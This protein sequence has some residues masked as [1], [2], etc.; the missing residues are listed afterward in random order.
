MGQQIKKNLSSFYV[1]IHP[2][3]L[4]E[5]IILTVLLDTKGV[6]HHLSIEK[7]PQKRSEQENVLIENLLGGNKGYRWLTS[8]L[9]LLHSIRYRTDYKV[10]PNLLMIQNRLKLLTILTNLLATHL[11][12]LDRNMTF[13]FVS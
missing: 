11:S 7:T 13:K 4:P 8:F 1:E 10:S 12:N 9:S 5:P 6:Q 3:Y 2:D